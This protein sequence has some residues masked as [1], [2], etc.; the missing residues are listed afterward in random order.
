MIPR[1]RVGRKLGRTLYLDNEVVGMVDNGELAEAIV[2]DL[3][4]SGNWKPVAD[5]L[6]KCSECKYIGF[7]DNHIRPNSQTCPNTG[8]VARRLHV[9]TELPK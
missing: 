8:E 5:R 9:S 1:W 3:N 6:E 7:L 2:R 4:A